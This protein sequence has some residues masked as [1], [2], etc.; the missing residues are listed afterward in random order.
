MQLQCIDHAKHSKYIS[1]VSAKNA[2]NAFVGG[3]KRAASLEA[4]YADIVILVWK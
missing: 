4:R 1:G 3:I 2:L